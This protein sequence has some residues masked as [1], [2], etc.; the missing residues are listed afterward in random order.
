MEVIT[1][2]TFPD[3]GANGL[4]KLVLEL[5]RVMLAGHSP[6]VSAGAG[7]GGPKSPQEP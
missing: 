7:S 2:V 4:G 5:Q 3:S 1:N 6:G